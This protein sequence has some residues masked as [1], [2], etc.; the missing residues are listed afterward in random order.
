M[1]STVRRRVPTSAVIAKEERNPGFAGILKYERSLL[2]YG[3]GGGCVSSDRWLGNYPFLDR[4]LEH[5]LRH[6]QA[7]RRP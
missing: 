2:T 6:Y 1:F 5:R 7:Y 3:F 4:W